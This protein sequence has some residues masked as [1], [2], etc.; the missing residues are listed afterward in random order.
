MEIIVLKDPKTKWL[1]KVR[2]ATDF[3][4]RGVRAVLPFFG[5]LVQ[6]IRPE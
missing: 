5:A 2:C 1:T 3:K 4:V 6:F